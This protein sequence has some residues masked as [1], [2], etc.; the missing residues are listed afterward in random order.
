MDAFGR[1]SVRQR[2]ACVAHPIAAMPRHLIYAVRMF[3]DRSHGP[4]S[5]PIIFSSK[6]LQF[7]V[8]AVRE[9]CRAPA[10]S[11]VQTVLEGRGVTP[12]LLRSGE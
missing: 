2:Q 8:I 11:H 4:G 6:A 5:Q 12:S 1:A 7:F 3:A 10:N 9:I